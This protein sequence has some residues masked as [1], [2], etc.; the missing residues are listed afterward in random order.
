MTSGA[1][2]GAFVLFVFLTA[3][4]SALSFGLEF[5]AE[6]RLRT[7]N[8][9]SI[10]HDVPGAYLEEVERV[11]NVNG[12]SSSTWFGGMYLEPRNFFMSLAVEPSRFLAMYPGIVLDGV[13][14]GEWEEV[15]N[16]VI[17]GQPLSEK[18]GWMK[19]DRVVLVTQAHRRRDGAAAWEFE[20]LGTYTAPAGDYAPGRF[21]LRQDYLDGAAVD[22]G[23]VSWVTSRLT[24]PGLA[25]QTAREIDG[26]FA[27]TASPT[28][29]QP[30]GAQNAEFA[31][32]FADFGSIFGQILGIVALI[33]AI[34]AGS[35]I[36]ESAR[37]RRSE[38]VLLRAI[39]FGRVRMAWIVVGESLAVVGGGAALGLGLGVIGLSLS[40]DALAEL[41]PAFELG[42]GDLLTGAGFGVVLA[43]AAAAPAVCWLGLTRG[44][45]RK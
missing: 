26:L 9:L 45:Q 10:I 28:V 33:A 27:T 44:S 6:N 5:A 8:R 23:R 42:W 37:R 38:F 35:T 7:V 15:R 41:L 24:E 36:G 40:Q 32:Q 2:A 14:L 31:R 43:G 11:P 19:G 12:T 34:L 18:F 1:T 21:L 16:G 30:E 22:S 13:S 3:L 17:V 4:R 25:A 20:V 39:G 29:T